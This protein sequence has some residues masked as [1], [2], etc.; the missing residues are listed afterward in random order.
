MLNRQ[1]NLATGY[2]DDSENR[3]MIEFF[4]KGEQNEFVFSMSA[5]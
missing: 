4:S 1:L 2:R 3:T 5:S